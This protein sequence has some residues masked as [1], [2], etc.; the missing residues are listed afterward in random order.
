MLQY[1]GRNALPVL[2]ASLDTCR[3]DI[4]I[5]FKEVIYQTIGAMLVFNEGDQDEILGV[6]KTKI[7][8]NRWNAV[9]DNKE[10]SRGE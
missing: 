7:R 10:E 8:F 6:N 9:K 4:H 2:L 5:P 1:Y 3:A